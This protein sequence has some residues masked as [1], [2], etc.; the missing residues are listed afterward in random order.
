MT[1][2]CNVLQKMAANWLDQP[3]VEM[4]LSISRQVVRI[5]GY[6]KQARN[7]GR[8]PWEQLDKSSPPIPAVAQVR[9][10]AEVTE[11]HGLRRPVILRLSAHLGDR[12]A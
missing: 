9:S 3:G 11:T 7:L 1:A 8:L 10:D 2:H 12:P 6:K 4:L 5:V